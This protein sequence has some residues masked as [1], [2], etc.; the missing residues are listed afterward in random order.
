MLM[1]GDVTE[2]VIGAAIEVHRVVGPGVLESIYERCLAHE[3]DLRGIPYARQVTV[4]IAYKG[5][6][7]RCPHRADFVIADS[8]VVD[9]KAIVDIPP[10]HV[11]TLLTYMRFL[12]MRVGLLINFHVPVLKDGIVRRVL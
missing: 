1:H 6:S 4:P 2:Q 8:V 10:V 12:E 11:A 9:L 5:L 7:F 3:L